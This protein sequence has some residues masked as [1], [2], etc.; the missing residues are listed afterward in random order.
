MELKI[1][2]Y[3]IISFDVKSGVSSKPIGKEIIRGAEN[4]N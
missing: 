2:N 4:R 1:D 3:E